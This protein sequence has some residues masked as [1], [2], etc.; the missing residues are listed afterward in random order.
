MRRFISITLSLLSVMFIANA[1]TLHVG[2]ATAPTTSPLATTTNNI[3]GY[4]Q[5]DNGVVKYAYK[6]N[7]IEAPTF[8]EKA[9][10]KSDAKIAFSVTGEDATKRTP[11]A[12]TYTTSSS[13]VFVYE[14][15]AGQ[16][17]YYKDPLDDSWWYVD[18]STTTLTNFNSQV[19]LIAKTSW[20][21]KTALACA[22]PC[23]FFPDVSNVDGFAGRAN[24][25]ETYTTIHDG[26]GTEFDST[27]SNVVPTRVTAD[28][29][30]AKYVEIRRGIYLFDTSG[31]GS[32]NTVT[33]ATFSLFGTGK[34]DVMSQSINVV[35]S[36][37]ASNNAIVNAD[38]TALGT[39]VFATAITIAT[40]STTAYNDF[41]LNA[42]GRAAI[43]LTGSTKLGTRLVSDIN[44]VEPTWSSNADAYVIANMSEAA[45]TANDPKLVV[46]FSPSASVTTPPKQEM[47]TVSMR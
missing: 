24:G 45:G 40:W 11:F 13:T 18:Y 34:N 4:I 27:A 33:A 44:N 7:Q 14:V 36:N 28:S 42:S 3:L 10:I 19:N 23:T 31:I 1:Q 20:W 9:Q 5:N 38:Y 21:A 37:P 32:G 43:S 30:S 2:G 39:T 25:S 26:A 17:Q 15:I 46:T 35:S 47:I 6:T 12:R 22:S 8:A 29:V 16:P 41:T